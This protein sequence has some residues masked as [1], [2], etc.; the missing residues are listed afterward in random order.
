MRSPGWPTFSRRPVSEQLH[1]CLHGPSGGLPITCR[2]SGQRPNSRMILSA[3]LWQR[4]RW[5]QSSV[6]AASP[7][8][9]TTHSVLSPSAV[10]KSVQ[11]SL[12]STGLSHVWSFELTRWDLWGATLPVEGQTAVVVVGDAFRCRT[13]SLGSKHSLFF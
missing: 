5:P 3:Q 2:H 4:H 8:M 1:Q 7:S 9:H 12:L 11:E 13:G 10:S 6:S